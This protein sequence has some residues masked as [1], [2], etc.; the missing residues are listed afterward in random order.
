MQESLKSPGSDSTPNK[1][2][3]TCVVVANIIAHTYVVMLA[4]LFN[5]SALYFMV[6][7]DNNWLIILQHISTQISS[8]MKI[9]HCLF[10]VPT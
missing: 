8:C 10:T 5:A 2:S 7:W 6:D 4:R 9:K 1:I 3:H